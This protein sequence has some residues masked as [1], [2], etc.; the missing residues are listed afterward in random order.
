MAY[1]HSKHIAHRDLK[2][3]NILVDHQ[4]TTKIADFG[5]SHNFESSNAVI[6]DTAG[7]WCFWR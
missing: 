4:G 5:V 6:N 7:T 3:E 1:M 2:P